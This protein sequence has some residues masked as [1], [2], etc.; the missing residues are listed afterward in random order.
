[1]II[2]GT[3][4]KAE[5][6]GDVGEVIKTGV[7]LDDMDLIMAMTSKELYSNPIGSMIREIVSN[8][9]DAN[10]ESGSEEAVIHISEELARLGW[11]V[12]QQALGPRSG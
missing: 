1:M 12:Y 11:K 6:E 9:W 3:L 8:A 7:S 5:I 2:S 4:N 10:T